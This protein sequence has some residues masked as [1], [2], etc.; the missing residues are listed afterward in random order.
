MDCCRQ[1]AYHMPQ[2]FGVLGTTFG[3]RCPPGHVRFG[4]AET[5]AL[6]IT[7][8]ACVQPFQGD[9]AR[10]NPAGPQ[11]G[12]DVGFDNRRVGRRYRIALSIRKLDALRADLKLQAVPRQLQPLERNR[13]IIDQS[14]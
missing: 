12:S 6:T 13:T 8:C 9:F 4:L 10:G 11:Q 7:D 5:K 14:G 2:V 1:R 3:F